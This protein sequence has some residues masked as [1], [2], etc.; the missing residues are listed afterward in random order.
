MKC[1]SAASYATTKKW[2]IWVVFK[3]F[4]LLRSVPSH[5][6][7]ASS[8]ATLRTSSTSK[9]KTFWV[10]VKHKPWKKVGLPHITKRTLKSKFYNRLDSLASSPQYAFDNCNFIGWHPACHDH[11]S[12]QLKLQVMRPMWCGRSFSVCVTLQFLRKL[13]SDHWGL[14]DWGAVMEG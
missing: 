13:S 7:P 11:P 3:L 8:F 4:L 1:E 10:V 6:K 2:F 5:W 9:N 14:R 12:F